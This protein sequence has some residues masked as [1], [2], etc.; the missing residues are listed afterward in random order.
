MLLL[1]VVVASSV[2]FLLRNR[3]DKGT[4]IV[5]DEERKEYAAGGGR[6]Y[7]ED[8]EAGA[9]DRS[10]APVTFDPNTADSAVLVAVGLAPWQAHNVLR[11]RKKGGQYHRPE[12]FKRLYGL[13]VSQWEQ[14]EP[15]IRIGRKFRYLA[16]V[17]DVNTASPPRYGSPRYQKVDHHGR[18]DTGMTVQRTDTFIHSTHP[19]RSNADVRK[20][21]VGESVD[22][23]SCDTAE[24]K[25]IPGIGTYY[26][27]RIAEYREKL[28]GFFS[29]SQL[30]DDALSFLPSGIERYMTLSPSSVRKLRVNRLTVRELSAHP[31]ISYPQAKQLYNRVRIYGPVNSWDDILF[32][33]EFTEAD[34][35]RLEAYVEF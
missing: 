3:D 9:I 20:L 1:G 12:D 32:L 5:T 34:R 16:D 35:H 13:T 6:E 10:G 2:F 15:R 19:F 31:Y 24:L 11:Y 33:S 4:P 25:R 28:G 7:A 29:L 14:L 23:A 8:E 22:I 17:E 27:R 18:A 21:R 26:A 30:N